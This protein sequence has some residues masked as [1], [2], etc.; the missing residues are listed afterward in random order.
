MCISRNENY[1]RW[2]HE[3]FEHVQNFHTNL[4]KLHAWEEHCLNW[5]SLWLSLPEWP[6]M[7]P[8]TNT[9]HVEW[10]IRAR[11]AVDSAQQWD[12]GITKESVIAIWSGHLILA[13]GW[14][15]LVRYSEKNYNLSLH[16]HE[17]KSNMFY[18][19]LNSIV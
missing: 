7:I 12:L 8:R 6:G 5:L 4:L 1:S 15:N 13:G 3:I 19:Y 16:V 2:V 18:I 9:N 11:P 10:S 17:K 14:E